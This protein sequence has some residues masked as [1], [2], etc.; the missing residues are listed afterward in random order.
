MIPDGGALGAR[1]AKEANDGRPLAEA[2]PTTATVTPMTAS[3][4][5]LGEPTAA[6]RS[7]APATARRRRCNLGDRV[8]TPLNVALLGLG[9]ALAASGL[10][11][12]VSTTSLLVNALRPGTPLATLPIALFFLAAASALVPLSLLARRTGRAP[13]FLA[14]TAAACAGAALQLG[15]AYAAAAAAV[16]SA[17][18][19]AL[20]AA[21]AAAPLAMLSL[22]AALQ[23]PSFAAANNYRFAAAEFVSHRPSRPRAISLVVAS[24]VLAAAL[25]PEAAR[26]AA[27]AV[28]SAPYAG[29]YAYLAALYAAQLLALCC[30]DWGLLGERQAADAELGALEAARKSREESG[31]LALPAGAGA[32]SEAAAAAAQAA[33]EGAGAK[34]AAATAPQQQ[35]Q[36]QVP[37]P[38]R[39]LLL[40]PDFVV[41]AATCA[42]AFASMAALMALAPLRVVGLGLGPDVASRAVVVHIA[43][44]YL[45]ALVMGDVVR[46][47]GIAAPM[48]AGFATLL[49]GTLAFLGA[50]PASPSPS[51]SAAAAYAGMVL[52]GVGWAAAYVSASALAASCCSGEPP[53]RRLPVQAATD[54]CVLL[55]SGL[56]MGSATPLLRAEHFGW[57]GILALYA[58]ANGALLAVALGWGGR[59]RWLKARRRERGGDR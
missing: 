38:Y 39:A 21:A 54:S 30:V 6:C 4:G 1:A 59:R 42:G 17:A 22:G 52:I 5:G 8:R 25:G 23:G 37:T 11:V 49:A 2:T 41:A 40:T 7:A 26:R 29:A 14:A 12:Q 47:G 53:G 58:S 50:S 35:H 9:W 34:P 19:G 56:A 45:P 15:A 43:A 51:A 46:V 3:D 48:A 16:P 13:V 28:P 32:A 10:F 24:A 31:L 36:R 27:P 55:L 33:E 18:S 20:P 57:T 44:M